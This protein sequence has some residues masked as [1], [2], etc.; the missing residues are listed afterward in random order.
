MNR[1]LLPI[2]ILLTH[3]SSAFAQ[4]K[5]NELA[6]SFDTIDISASR[7]SNSLRAS[8]WGNYKVDMDLMSELPKIFGN[9]DPIH[10]A[11]MLPGVQTQGEYSAG[12]H[13][14]GSE[15]GHNQISIEGVP[16]YGV[17]H[18]LGFFSVFNPTHYKE[19]TLN[20][21][22]SDVVLPNRLGASLD[23]CTDH[24]RPDSLNGQYSFGLI[25][26]Q[27]TLNAPV[28]KK[29]TLTLSAR[30]S[31]MGLLYSRW[32]EVDEAGANYSFS[33]V[34][35]TWLTDI[36]PKDKI[37][38]DTYWGQDN[39]DFYTDRNVA[40]I[41]STWGNNSQA[42]H[43]YHDSHS[44][45]TMNASL[46]R[47]GYS[48]SLTA[49]Q[50]GIKYSLPSDIVDYGL[51]YSAGCRFLRSGVEL[52][53]HNIGIQTPMIEGAYNNSTS[54]LEHQKSEE[55]SVYTDMT[56]NISGHVVS[57]VGVRGTNYILPD[58]DFKVADASASVSYYADS[59]W[60]LSLNLF[61]RH[62][63]L[64][65]TGVNDCGMP[66][67]FWLSVGGEFKPQMCRGFNLEFS[68][69]LLDGKYKLTSGAY[70]KNLTNQVS[71][72]GSLL[73]YV[74][75]DY[76]LN[77]HLLKG[78]GKNYGANIMILKTDG[79]LTGWMSYSYGRALRRFD[80]EG[81]D[82]WY[83]AAHE[84]IHELDMVASYRLNDRFSV[85]STFVASG[86]TPYTAPKY[87]YVLQ[88]RIITQYGDYNASRLKPYVRLD[89]SVDMKF[90]KK[91]IRQIDSH[92]MNLSFYNL[93]CRSNDLYYRL[94]V[95]NG[96][97]YYRH[98]TFFVKVLPSLS[99]YVSF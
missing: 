75:T 53:H 81:M 15:Q 32:L 77:A 23:F 3:F 28:G 43:W 36:G 64:F 95:Y 21:T 33:D 24:N 99:Y 12:L 56:F 42:I 85:S 14:N 76:D 4:Q 74:N 49:Y 98:T 48:N 63:F 92:G 25:S 68:T 27:G 6:F 78:K 54:S 5:E 37:S 22:A 65:Q 67:E 70:F 39:A 71:Y 69:P 89:A 38:V 8:G 66:V 83:P 45:L 11:Q 91:H 29:S 7:Y 52:I 44:N 47:T 82:K 84:R 41:V 35:A 2:I 62:Q 60:K 96:Y 10:Y 90:R 30:T 26:L 58:E 1:R 61:Q 17:S 19:M 50:D 80:H 88:G 9:S 72:Y 59:D 97:Y 13:V 40:D 93:T 87:L 55:L 20:T 46:Y 18:L 86:G 34:N 57:T 51:R 79:T 73:D 94:K 31:Y 16:L